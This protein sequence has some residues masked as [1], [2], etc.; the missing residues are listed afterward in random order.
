DW[1]VGFIAAGESRAHE[2]IRHDE[3]DA[4]PDGGRGAGVDWVVG[5]LFCGRHDGHREGAAWGMGVVGGAAPGVPGFVVWV[6]ISRVDVA[7]SYVVAA[8]LRRGA[9]G[10][11]DDAR[12]RVEEARDVR[13]YSSRAAV[14]TGRRAAL[15]ECDC[16]SRMLQHFVCGLGGVEAEG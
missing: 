6:R 3:V 7:I 9:D 5:D 16:D 15:G 12:W 1:G 10:G 4:V 2:R 14:V 13:D 11:I 8:G